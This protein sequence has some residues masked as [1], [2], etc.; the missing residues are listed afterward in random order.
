ME[1]GFY[2]FLS[3][4]W[5][6][7]KEY[8]RICLGEKLYD[9]QKRFIKTAFDA[10]EN[11]KHKV[12]VLKS[13]QLGLSTISRALSAFY[14][15]MHDGMQGALV[16]DT[17]PHRD[18]ARIELGK[19][20][21]N[22][23]PS[24]KFPRV[25]G[26]GGAGNRDSLQLENDARILFLSAGTQ[27]RTTSGTLGRSEGL[28]MAHLSELCSYD[29]PEGLKAFEQ[30]M[31]EFHPDRLYIYESTARGYNQWKDMWDT[32][33]DDTAH[34]STLFLG[35]WSRE[36]QRIDQSDGDFEIYGR[37]PPSQ[38]ERERIAEVRKSYGV[39]ISPEQLAWIRR[40]VDPTSRPDGDTDAGFEAEDNVMLAEQAWTAEEAFQQT[41]SKFFGAKAL[42]EITKKG[43]S[44]KFKAYM[45]WAGEEFPPRIFHA[46]NLKMTELKVW[47]EP[48]PDGVYVLACD[49]AYGENEENDH[50]AIQVCRCYADG[51]DQVAEYSWPLV[52]TYQL[53]W[54]IASLL[55]W[56]GQA[57]AE[58]R[59]I[60]ELNGPGTAVFNE[61]KN[62]KGKVEAR[63]AAGDD[64]K[65]LADIFRNVRTYIYNRPDAMGAGFNYHW[66][67]NISLKVTVMERLR[68]F[69]GNGKLKVRSHSLLS[70]M[71]SVARE[72]DSIS[73]PRGMRDD[74]TFA[75]SLAVHYWET[76]IV[77]PLVAQRKTREAE[78]ARK[79]LSIIDQV[80]LFNQNHLD[81]YFSQKRIVRNNLRSQMIRNQWR[82]QGRRW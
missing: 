27:Q 48:D 22:L 56:Y 49:P 41:G 78:A 38:R 11:D 71:K 67:T 25:L 75:M 30:S 68:D 79:R 28:T 73:A 44:N 6:N 42:T 35:W 2:A 63:H 39:E 76:K 36:D 70:E 33:C 24:L 72:G 66:K 34:C 20:I 61:L 59:Y 74:R 43:A 7:S 37:E 40:K 17:M 77:I 3:R 62:L 16:F 13:R 47:E 18:S 12:F 10:L 54:V 82:S 32:A 60:L 50:S 80:S 31:S 26:V 46:E 15:G 81:M 29:N 45:Y 19:L 52:T 9:G 53:A 23:D 1:R 14:I 65:G 64:E 57:R 4:T 58:I 8:G 21:R 51:L 69:V 5:V 55:G